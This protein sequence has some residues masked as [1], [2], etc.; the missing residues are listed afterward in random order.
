MTQLKAA[1]KIKIQYTEKT[2]AN[3]K[4]NQ[5]AKLYIAIILFI[6]DK[7]NPLYMFQKQRQKTSK[8]EKVVY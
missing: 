7:A 2:T 6:S 3:K 4:K 8:Q 1:L 5:K